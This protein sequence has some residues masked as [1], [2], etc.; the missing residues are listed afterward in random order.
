MKITCNY[1]DDIPIYPA[2]SLM[3]SRRELPAILETELKDTFKE[4]ILNAI[5]GEISINNNKTTAIT[6]TIYLFSDLKE[7]LS[8]QMHCKSKFPYSQKMLTSAISCITGNKLPTVY[9]RC[10]VCIQ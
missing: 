3:N 8:K 2:T 4:T 7:S 9:S 6:T 10:I 5:R 1:G